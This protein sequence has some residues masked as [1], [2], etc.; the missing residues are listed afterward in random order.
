MARAIS[1]NG[2]ANTF[3]IA[4]IHSGKH[5]SPT[6][7]GDTIATWSKI[8]KKE[9][10]NNSIGSLMVRTLA[11][12]NNFEMCF[13]EEKTLQEIYCIRPRIFCINSYWKKMKKQDLTLTASSNLQT[14]NNLNFINFSQNN[15]FSL[16]FSIVIMVYGLFSLSLGEKYFN[17]FLVLL[18][19]YPLKLFYF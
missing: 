15:R 8:L 2:L 1:C 14:A 11:S 13:P 19:R 9:E 17:F 7:S 10:I 16:N 4:A 18:I 5:S 6:F 12:K 3:K